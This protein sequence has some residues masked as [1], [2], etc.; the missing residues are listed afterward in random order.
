MS[1]AEAANDVKGSE[2]QGLCA[3]PLIYWAC[4]VV[5]V[6]AF[7]KPQIDAVGK[8]MWEVAE[9]KFNPYPKSNVEPNAL[10]SLD[11]GNLVT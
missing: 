3:R 6:T 9:E 5:V 7:S 11:F 8:S 10:T 4:F 2:I 1:L